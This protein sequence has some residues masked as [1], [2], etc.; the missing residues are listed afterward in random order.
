MNL[1]ERDQVL[2]VLFIVILMGFGFYRGLYL[3]IHKEIQAFT[4]SNRQLQME[5]E[6]LQAKVKKLPAKPQQTE[7]QY[8]NLNKRLPTDDEMICLLTML[9]ETAG[10]HN[11]PFAS[12]DYKG[13]EKPSN[14]IEQ[15]L[16]GIIPPKESKN[17]KEYESG[18]QTLVFNIGTK[19][20]I[21]QLLNFLDDLEKAERLISVEEVSFNAVKA[22]TQET[23]VVDEGPP[24]YYIAPPDI[25][26]AKLQRIKFEVVEERESVTESE[27]LV[28]ESFIANM[29]EMKITIKAYYAAQDK[30]IQAGDADSEN[31]PANDSQNTSGKV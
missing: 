11:L 10:K 17:E 20:Q 31:K 22:E 27:R 5:K 3:P 13:A 14:L 21:T 24:A 16:A 23:E 12:L 6:S 7:D 25:P 30:A 15:A 28:A 4:A 29:F 18:V 19:G 1:S 26:E 9:N 2:L 8:A